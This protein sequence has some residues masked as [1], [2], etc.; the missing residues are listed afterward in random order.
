MAVEDKIG[1]LGRAA[2]Y[3]V[4]SACES[5]HPREAADIGHWVSYAVRADG[6]RVPLL[7][8]LQSNICE[9]DCAYCAF[10]SGRDTPRTAFTPDELARLFD[11]LVRRRLVEGLFLSSGVCGNVGRATE[12]MLATVEL[13][14]KRYAFPGYVHLK[15]LPGAEEAAIA[16][17]LELANR[18]SV[19]VEAP[20]SHRLRA[21]SK[22][23]EIEQLLGPLRTAHRLRT[24]N[25]KRVSMTTQF[26]VGA[27]GES[28]REILSLTAVLYR[29]VRL[30]R[31]YFSAF[32]PVRGTPL[33]GH[34]P[35]PTWR[36]HRLYQADFLLRQYGFRVD[37]LVF[38][39]MGHLL[40]GADPKWAWAYS[41]P[42][43][44]PIEVNTA[45]RD[46]LLRVPGIGPQSADD[47]LARRRQGRLRTLKDL[48]LSPAAARRAAPW[49]LLAGRRPEFQLSLWDA[50]A[51][52]ESGALF[53]ETTGY[54]SHR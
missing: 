26:V 14:R 16:A 1:L 31:A 43:H 46:E 10:R 47:I 52:E 39:E 49:I 11:E 34:P 22:H 41:H 48:G 30:S 29:E 5:V 51:E 45:T 13:V 23:K 17:S 50:V 35:T 21:L 44:F 20:G 37:E 33:E 12:R 2:Q 8:V 6:K 9:N 54:A 38:D 7:K 24:E 19:N 18:V 28:D 15:I 32:R 53:K 27:A 42:D 36:E 3:D 40:A 25:E 4:C